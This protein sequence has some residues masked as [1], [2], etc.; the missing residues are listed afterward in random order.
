MPAVTTCTW[1]PL[2][3]P[4]RYATHTH[5]YSLARSGRQAHSGGAVRRRGEGIVRGGPAQGERGACCCTA[6]AAAA[7]W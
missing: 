4:C 5:C 7:L 1:T 3:G 6:A 2:T